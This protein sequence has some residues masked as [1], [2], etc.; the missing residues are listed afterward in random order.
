[1]YLP[2]GQQTKAASIRFSTVPEPYAERIRGRYTCSSLIGS[3][4]LLGDHHSQA[5]NSVSTTEE[6]ARQACWAAVDVCNAADRIAKYVRHGFDMATDET[7][8]IKLEPR[9]QALSNPNP[10]A[11]RHLARS[12]IRCRLEDCTRPGGSHHREAIRRLTRFC[13]AG[14]G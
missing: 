7:C 3:T 8:P 12:R 11:S 2:H 1:M 14:G 5:C 4:I 10:S 6:A 9:C 13:G